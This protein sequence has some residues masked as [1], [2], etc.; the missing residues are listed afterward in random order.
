MRQAVVLS[1]VAEPGGTALMLRWVSLAYRQRLQE[2]WLQRADPFGPAVGPEF[3]PPAKPVVSKP[4]SKTGQ[5]LTEVLS[6]R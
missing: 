3:I 1:R 5:H 6:T 2:H 4:R